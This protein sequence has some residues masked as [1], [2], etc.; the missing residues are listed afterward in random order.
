MSRPKNHRPAAETGSGCAPRSLRGARTS[1]GAIVH[2][3]RADVLPRVNEEAAWYR[4]QPGL[5]AAID[6]AARSVKADGKRHGHQTRIPGATLEEAAR[7]LQG[8]DPNA[9]LTFHELWE[10]VDRTIG[11]LHRVGE[12]LVY[13][14][15]HRIGLFLGL[16][17][18]RVYLHRGARVGA[19]A[20]GL[21]KGRAWLDIDDL[22]AP[23]RVLSASDLENV[24]CIYKD[25]LR[26]AA[27]G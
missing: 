1:F 18:E 13:D 27:R 7:R 17:P 21:G 10:T 24:L 5:R 23:L 8:V 2:A 26:E 15:A 19:Q 16:E 20:L 4:G 9:C 14:A 12:L 25:D 22:P 6:V 11:G 3:Y